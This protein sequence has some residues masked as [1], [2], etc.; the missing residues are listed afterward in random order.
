MRIC[1]LA[2]VFADLDLRNDLARIRLF[3]CGQLID[4]AEDRLAA[5]RDKPLADAEHIDAGALPQ[6]VL[7][8]MLIQRS[9]RR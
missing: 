6:Q 5:G 3:H 8:Q 2:N 1:D 9:W 7:D 4:A